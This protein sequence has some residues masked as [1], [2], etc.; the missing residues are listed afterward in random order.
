MRQQYHQRIA[1]TL[2]GRF[3]ETAKR[4]PERLARHYTEAGLH[5]PAIGYWQQAGHEAI[6]GSAHLE[7]IAHLTQ[8][9]TLLTAQPTMPKRLHQ[10]LDFQVALGTALRA[11]QGSSAPEV[12]RAY[13]R[14]QTLCEQIGETPQLFPVLRG[15]MQYY[16]QRGQL[17]TT[18]TLGEQLLRLAQSQS[19]TALLM[20]AHSQ[21]GTVLFFQG[22]PAAAQTHHTQALTIYT[23]QEHRALA[24]RYGLDLGVVSGICLSLGLWQL[25][26]PDQAM[27]HI[28]EALSLA[29]EVSHPYSLATALIIAAIVHQ[30]RREVS[31][32][33]AQAAAAT[34]L[35]MEQGFAERLAWSTALHGWAL[36][37]QGQSEA[38]I[39]ELRQGLD[40][41]LATGSM[42]FQPYFLGLLAE[43]YGEAGQP[44]AGLHTLGEVAAM[45]PTTESRWYQAELHR[46]KGTL[47]LRRDIHAAVEAEACLHE[48]LAVA[49]HQRAKSWELRAATSLARLW[50]QQGRCPEA[51]SLLSS[52]YGWFTEGFDTADLIGAKALLDD[53]AEG[54]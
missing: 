10:E 25:G 28:Q 54:R 47:L 26:Y 48:A 14:A 35:T 11:V 22:E 32:A 21:L 17:Q 13:A 51:Y 1:Q 8:G 9:L 34:T 30:H 20:L 2:E 40:A 50:Q 18:Y 49:R 45:L 46:L 31:A 15:L 52:V 4:E 24:W 43:A 3:P 38:G 36:A 37:M 33:R 5:E 29:Q 23:P 7:A 53:L 16:Q 19:D 39:A 12:E 44:D 27:Q 41:D 42:L 6:Q